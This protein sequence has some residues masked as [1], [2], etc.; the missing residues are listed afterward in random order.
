MKW[1]SVRYW[2]SPL[3]W[4]AELIYPFAYRRNPHDQQ[5]VSVLAQSRSGNPFL[6][7]KVKRAADAVLC[8]LAGC[9]ILP[10]FILWIALLSI[11]QVI[12]FA[13][14]IWHEA[15]LIEWKSF[16]RTATK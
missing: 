11:K 8:F 3:S 5:M 7:D 1:T 10:L 4:L 2:L 6:L 15:R 14:S 9:V 12:L 13:L 16:R